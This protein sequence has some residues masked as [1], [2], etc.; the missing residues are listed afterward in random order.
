[1]KILING[2]EL[3]TKED[4]NGKE[5][6]VLIDNGE[7]YSY[8]NS[9]Y[10]EVKTKPKK[11]VVRTLNFRTRTHEG[12]L[13]NCTCRR[14]EVGDQIYAVLICDALKYTK[15]IEPVFDKKP[16]KAKDQR[17]MEAIMSDIIE[18]HFIIKYWRSQKKYPKDFRRKI[19]NDTE[20]SLKRHIK[21]LTKLVPGIELQ[22]ETMKFML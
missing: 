3:D 14:T 10:N 18:C 9:W 13:L 15:A 5:T 19:I 6:W 12:L 1:M 21:A 7:K 11:D 22:E 16:K 20:K 4:P 17:T 8:F 2:W